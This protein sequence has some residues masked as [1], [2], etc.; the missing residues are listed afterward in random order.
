MHTRSR[1]LIIAVVAL[2]TFAA[3]AGP[4]MASG[5]ADGLG[6]FVDVDGAVEEDS[7]AALWEA[8]ITSGCGPWLFCPDEP[9]SR[10]E[11][12]AFLVRALGLAPVPAPVGFADATAGPFAGEI[13]ALVEAGISQGCAELAFCPEA[14]VTRGQMATMIARALDLPPSEDNPFVDD[15]GSIHADDI[16]RVAAAGIVVGCDIDRFCVHRALT[17]AELAVVLT[18]A[19]GLEPPSSMPSIPDDVV[20]A[21]HLS[22]VQYS[23]PSAGSDAWRPLVTTYFPSA[24]VDRA[25][26]ILACESNGDPDAVNPRSGAAGLFQHLPRFWEERSTA[27]GY[28]GSDV[29]DPVANVAVAAWL[30]YEAPAGGWHHWV[31]K[32]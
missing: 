26:R 5:G 4:A 23:W 32:G 31:C 14:N 19:F 3:T 8:G 18:R 10:G 17:R 29:F 25:M 2:A 20:A 21:Y 6:P 27:A 30:A 1:I 13:G 9:V 28:G 11:T 12:A 24:D 7:V 22:S 15:E 16:G